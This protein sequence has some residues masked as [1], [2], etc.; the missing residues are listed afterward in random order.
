MRVTGTLLVAAGIALLGALA[1]ADDGARK[2][3]PRAAFA[4]TDS[5]QDGE[6]DRGEFHARIVEIF[7]S[8][9]ANKDGFLDP[10]ELKRL[11]FPEDFTEND[12]D[13]D[14]RVAMREF[15]RVR[16]HDFD[17]ADTNDDGVLSLDEV[18]SAYE[19][20]KRR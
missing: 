10:T 9:D 12:K 11:A 5:N 19:G 17:V 14:G 8:A 13:R 15:L 1:R 4:E 3:D 18:V 16:F 6:V 2:Y 20:K 7:Y